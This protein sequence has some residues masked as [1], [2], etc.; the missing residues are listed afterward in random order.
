MCQALFRV[1]GNTQCIGYKAKSL[2]SSCFQSMGVGRRNEAHLPLAFSWTSGHVWDAS[3]SGVNHCFSYLS[4]SLIIPHPHPRFEHLINGSWW[5]GL[6]NSKK[7]WVMLCKATQDGQ[8]MV[9]SSDKAWS[10]GGGNCNPPQYS[11]LKNP[12]NSMKKQKDM[13]VK[14]EPPSPCVDHNKFWKILQEM[15]IPDHR[16][17]LRN[18]YVGQEATVRIGHGTMDWFKT[19]KG[20]HQGCI[21]SPCLFNSYAGHTMR[22]A[23]LNESQAAIKIARRNI[24]NLRYAYDT[25]LMA[26]KWRGTKE[27]LDEGETADWKAGLKLNIQKSK[28]TASSPI[29]SWQTEGEKWK[30]WYIF[31]PRLQSNC[32]QWLQPWN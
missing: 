13:T 4:N 27:P 11:C 24:S 6:C 31:F 18:L 28:I 20:V 16:T 25:T 14:D 12:I 29:T 23:G 7:L 10:T 9:E 30:W 1:L 2:T 26:E 8:V 19:W 3:F 5:R 21:L 15:G 17:C 32:R 22:N